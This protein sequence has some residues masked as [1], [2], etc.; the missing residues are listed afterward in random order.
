[1]WTKEGWVTGGWRKLPS[2]ELHNLCS[3]PC[4]IFN[5]HVKEDEM[6]KVK[7]T[8]GREGNAY[9]LLVRKPKGKRPLGRPRLRLE[10]NVKIDI[11]EIMGWKEWIGGSG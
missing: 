1:M 9:I 4:I 7:S 2:K 3:L 8:N 11:V 5:Y 6:N 10:D